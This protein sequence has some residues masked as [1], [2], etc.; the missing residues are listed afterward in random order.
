MEIRALSREELPQAIALA[1]RVFLEFE[2]PEY[3]Q[4]GVETFLAFIHSPASVSELACFGAFSEGDIVGMIA[5]R[6]INHISLFFVETAWQ[7]RGIG[8]ALFHAARDACSADTIT[9]NSSPYAVE[10]YRSLGFVPLIGEQVK[11]GI[12][13]TPMRYQIPSST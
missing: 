12:R 7:G 9:V 4:Q 3:E 2:A 10:I 11:D 8:R 1:E 13:F 5:M 6:N